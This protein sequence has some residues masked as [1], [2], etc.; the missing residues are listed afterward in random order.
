MLVHQLLYIEVH[1]RFLK[2][3]SLLNSATDETPRH[4]LS[5]LLLFSLVEYIVKGTQNG[6]L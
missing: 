5:S 4:Y 1:A 6:N 3:L 2:M